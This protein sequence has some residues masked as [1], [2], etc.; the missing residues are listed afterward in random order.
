MSLYAITAVMPALNEAE[1]LGAAVANVLESYLTRGINGQLIIVDDGSS[2]GTGALADEYAGRYPQV[3]VL[4]HHTPRGIG[5]SFWEGVRA[6]SGEIVTM[7]PGDGE[8]DAAEILRYLP[9]L[10]EVDIVIPYVYNRAIRTWGRRLL[11]IVYREIV[12][13][14]FG[15]SLN[16]MNGTVMYRRCILADLELVN[17]GFFYQTELL[18]KSIHRGYLYAEVP[19]ALGVRGGG[20]SRAT[21]WRSLLRVGIGFL[22]TFRQIHFFPRVAGV[23]AGSVTAGRLKE[24]N[25]SL[26]SGFR[27]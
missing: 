13:A 22:T 4:H 2:D 10:S 8:N 21:T 6:A 17:G 11:S 25:Q 16:Y 1:N 20:E 26:V 7:I 5:A 18:I 3:E 14:G 24:L 9:L 15:L 23:A 19:C 27:I 12:K